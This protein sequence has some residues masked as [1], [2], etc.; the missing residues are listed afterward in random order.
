MTANSKV[1]VGGILLAAG[2]SRRMGTPKQLLNFKGRSLIR[3]AA[4]ALTGADCEPVVVVLGA[5]IEQSREQIADLSVTVVENPEWATGMS[6]SIR[7]GLKKLLEIDSQLDA[8][9]ITL[10]D[11]P[12]VTAE[13]LRPFIKTFVR[14][15]PDLIAAHYNDVAGVPALFSSKHFSD[16][17]SLEG[18]KGAREIIRN[19]PDAMT[20]PLPEAAID[21]DRKSDLSR[22]NDRIHP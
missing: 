19:S 12:F 11:Q 17:L 8:V 20:I 22:L 4:E 6:L 7:A 2:A 10:C 15:R 21:V 1:K 9:M 16:L 3:R 14:S 13:K 18:D 5:E